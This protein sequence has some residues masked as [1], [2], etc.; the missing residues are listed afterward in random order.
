MTNK[1]NAGAGD[2]INR[3][4]GVGPA[5]GP[6]PRQNTTAANDKGPGR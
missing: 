2:G 1:I 6:A 5:T 4:V 3:E